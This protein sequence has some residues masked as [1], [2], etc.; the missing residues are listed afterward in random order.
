MY[1][2]SRN[3]A[4]ALIYCDPSG[5]NEDDFKVYNSIDFNFNVTNWN[6]ESTDINHR[7][8]FTG[9]W[10]HCVEIEKVA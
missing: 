9:F 1:Y 4:V 8:N 6:D 5:L 3:L 10:D 2:L 7:C